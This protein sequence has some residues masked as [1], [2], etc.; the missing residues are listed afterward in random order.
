MKGSGDFDG[1]DE[2]PAD[3]TD[4]QIKDRLA[5]SA[6]QYMSQSVGL[7]WPRLVE[8]LFESGAKTLIYDLIELGWGEKTVLDVGSLLGV[9][10]EDGSWT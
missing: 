7:D 8:D 9:I 2:T 1:R 10:Y 6:D 3:L 5:S 4:E